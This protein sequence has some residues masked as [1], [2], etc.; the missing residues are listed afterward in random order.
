MFSEPFTS[1]C[2]PDGQPIRKALVGFFASGLGHMKYLSINSEVRTTDYTTSVYKEQVLQCN[3]YECRQLVITIALEV[4]P[5]L[6]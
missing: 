3:G 1:S 2:S 6:Q 4:D 5:F